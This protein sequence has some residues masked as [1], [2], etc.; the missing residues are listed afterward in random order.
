MSIH[1]PKRV[2]HRSSR[3]SDSATDSEKGG[4]TLDWAAVVEGKVAKDFVE[5]SPRGTFPA[6]T[7]VQHT[8][9]GHGL[10]VSVEAGKINVL[11]ENGVRKLAHGL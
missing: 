2:T 6:G 1:R 7:L 3:D 8:T 11:F 10:V 9:F 5:Y 4:K